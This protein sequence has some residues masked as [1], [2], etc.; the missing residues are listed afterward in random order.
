LCEIEGRLQQLTVEP[1]DLQQK[2]K[3][4][5]EEE[6]A[7]T[8][9][10]PQ[11][12]AKLEAI[13]SDRLIRSE[14]LVFQEQA[15]SALRDLLTLDLHRYQ[16]ERH[17][18]TCFTEKIIGR[19]HRSNGEKT[20]ICAEESMQGKNEAELEKNMKYPKV[21]VNAAVILKP[22]RPALSGPGGRPA[23]PRLS[24]PGGGGQASPRIKAT[25]E[26][27]FSPALQLPSCTFQKHPGSN[28]PESDEWLHQ[29]VSS[30]IP[31]MEGSR[32]GHVGSNL[33][34]ANSVKDLL[35][36]FSGPTPYLFSSQSAFSGHRRVLRSVSMESL[37]SSK[38]K[39][40]VF[41]PSAI[42]EVGSS[43]PSKD[44]K[45]N[46]AESIKKEVKSTS[47][48]ARVDCPVE[49]SAQKTDSETTSKL[50]TPKSGRDSVGDSGLGSESEVDSN[51]QSDSPSEEEPSTPR[52]TIVAQNPKYQLLLNHDL[53]TN[54]LSSREANGPGGGG[55]IGDKSPRLSRWETTRLGTN[56]FR[57]SLESLASRDWDTGTDRVSEEDQNT[58][59][60][61]SPPRVFNSPYATTTSMDYTPAFR[62]SEYKV[63]G[64]LSPATS[65]MNLYSY[66]SR[67]SSPI[68]MATP[69]L[70]A[71]RTRFSTYDTLRRRSEM[72]NTHVAPVHYSMRSATL[73]APNKK[74]FIEEL[75]KQLDGCQKRNAFL[76]AESVEMEKERNQIRFEMRALLVN[77]ED[78]LRTNAQ[79]NN[80]LKRTREQM[81]EME[82]ESQGLRERCREM[83]I[84]VK[85]AREMMVEANDQ[86]YA[87]NFLQQSLK[88]KIQDAEDNLEKQTQHAQSL[89]EKL[90]LT[91]RQLEEMEVDKETRDKKT[92]ELNS[93]ILRLEEELSEALKASTQNS[94]ELNLH[95]KLREDAQMRVEELE[96]ALLEKDQEVQKLQQ[97]VSKLQGEVSGKLIDKERSLEEEI[98][99]RER[100]QLQ[101]R[102]AERTVDDLTMEL[103]STNQAK[104]DLAKQLK[105]AQEK[106]IDMETD[107]EELL[108]SEQRW[109][110]KHKK[111]IE[112]VGRHPQADRRRCTRTSTGPAPIL[113]AVFQTEQ[114]QLKLIQ[115]KDLNDQLETDKAFM[116]R[117]IR[118]LRKE[119][120]ELQSSRVQ[121]D[122]VSRAEIRA[123][124]L[125]SALRAEE[126]NKATL[127]NS[128]NKLERKINELSDQLEEETRIANEQKELM[129]QRMRTL[130]RQLNEAEEEATRKE[131]QYRHL[132]RELAEERE[133]SSRLQ[134][135]LLDQHLQTKRKDNLTIRQTLDS[136]RLDLSG[137]E[138]DEEE[139]KPPKVKFPRRPLLVDTMNYNRFIL[140][141]AALFFQNVFSEA[142]YASDSDHGAPSWFDLFLKADRRRLRCLVCPLEGAAA[143]LFLAAPFPL[144]GSAGGLSTHCSILFITRSSSVITALST[145]TPNLPVFV[146]Q[147]LGLFLLNFPLVGEVRLV[148]DQNDVRVLAVGVGLQLACDSV[149]TATRQRSKGQRNLRTLR[150]LC[151]LVRSNISR[152]PM[153][154]LKN[155]VVR[156]RNLQHKMT[157]GH[158]ATRLLKAAVQPAH[159][160]DDSLLHYSPLVT[161]FIHINSP[162]SHRTDQQ[163]RSWWRRAGSSANY[164][165][166]G[167]RKSVLSLWIR[168]VV[169]SESNGCSRNEMKPVLPAAAAGRWAVR[170]RTE[171]EQELESSRTGEP[172]GSG[173]QLK[174][175]N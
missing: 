92:S 163:N 8:T 94:A 110:A 41:T 155:A 29:P 127:T 90:W 85:D 12:T 47:I 122:V 118:E 72:N 116:E 10:C 115:E 96:E 28:T 107:L 70:T 68:G 173:L 14:Q 11:T 111:T 91:E 171:P 79:L 132:Q 53:K 39:L 160:G 2:K 81:I 159:P 165:N 32:G 18:L 119:V 55:S 158:D 65:E 101:C 172:A 64:G 86:E 9:S 35:S 4:T 174:L 124:E 103:Q 137:D 26:R 123:K 144:A 170:T 154:S 3:Q 82:K 52:A 30:Q 50:K 102:Q 169:T 74:D 162:R 134:R 23:Q 141:S 117:Q 56:N 151:W 19:S 175:L 51:K 136:L 77:N 22:G 13:V 58:G 44:A 147:L 69:S 61:D 62:M 168:H 45:Q 27:V 6:E 157:D 142:H 120:E 16:E 104:D 89:A 128:I 40:S 42:E 97:L 75:T 143:C 100:L 49:D 126:R 31:S 98:Q 78:L 84:E 17:K 106:L 80:E 105:V 161:S 60:V 153:A 131:A 167:G 125:E 20:F 150:K 135:Q 63:Q 113:S 133:S 59:V 148:P 88:N 109:A 152:K 145:S 166:L 73:G 121:E 95:L 108:E 149:A 24:V 83:E 5:E 15:L 139:E 36:R 38:S 130:K 87:F 1:P 66:N 34:R 46:E 129:T 54:G 43:T 114:L 112:Q 71:Q 57:G 99:L 21:N 93:T 7:T 76:E 164:S 25:L 67:S 37:N 33:R 146:G 140:H 156:L 138:D 48:T